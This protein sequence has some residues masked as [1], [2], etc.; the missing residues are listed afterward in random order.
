[1]ADATWQTY[2]NAAIGRWDW[3]QQLS[4]LH[5]ELVVIDPTAWTVLGHQL[6]AAP[7]WKVLYDQDGVLIVE[8]VPA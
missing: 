1:M 4:N 6:R 2:I 3:Q 8:R 7:E 5:A